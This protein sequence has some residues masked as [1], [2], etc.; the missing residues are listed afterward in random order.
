MTLNVKKSLPF[1]PLIAG[2]DTYL[3][4]HKP[5]LMESRPRRHSSGSDAARSPKKKI[6]FFGLAWLQVLAE[7]S[8]KV[9]GTSTWDAGR[10]NDQVLRRLTFSGM[11]AEVYRLSYLVPGYGIDKDDIS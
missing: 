5:L 2:G 7:T 8:G 10:N 3:R 9:S 1:C 6:A 11:L 4:E